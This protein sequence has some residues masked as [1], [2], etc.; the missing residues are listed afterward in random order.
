MEDH[1]KGRWLTLEEHVKANQQEKI[2]AQATLLELTS[3]AVMELERG[4]DYNHLETAL[5]QIL[6]FLETTWP[7][8]Q[9][10][11][12]VNE[13]VMIQVRYQTEKMEHGAT[14]DLDISIDL[15]DPDTSPAE[16]QI[17]S[18]KCKGWTR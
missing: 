3:K 2:A 8:G 5:E 17:G 11:P 12:R 18:R 9:A 15:G 1:L 14:D 6:E 16:E 7:A 13:M 4:G 10:A